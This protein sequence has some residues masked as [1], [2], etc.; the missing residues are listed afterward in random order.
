MTGISPATAWALSII[1]LMLEKGAQHPLVKAEKLG[2][3][4]ELRE[5]MTHMWVVI[6][7]ASIAG[8]A[9]AAICHAGAALDACIDAAAPGES[10]DKIVEIRDALK[11]ELPFIDGMFR[12]L[13]DDVDETHIAEWLLANAPAADSATAATATAPKP[14][15]PKTGGDPSMN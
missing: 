7:T 6:K 8:D 1:K 14:P 13:L 9:M 3:P 12:T 10:R 4:S 11:T 15:R 5:Q 2:V